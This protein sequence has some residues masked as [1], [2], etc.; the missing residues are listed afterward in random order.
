MGNAKSGQLK[1][2]YLRHKFDIL[3]AD[4]DKLIGAF[5]ILKFPEV[6]QDVFI[7][8]ILDPSIYDEYADIPEFTKKLSHS[9]PAICDFH[10][11][12]INAT[13]NE[14]YDLV[15]EYGSPFNFTLTKEEEIWQFIE[16]LLEGLTYLEAVGLH[17]P[18]LH[19]KYIVIV[20]SQGIKLVNPYCF[21]DFIK[22][23]LQIYLNPQNPVSNR[24]SYA[25][26]QISR[27]IREFAVLV[28][29][30]VSDCDDYQLRTDPQYLGKLL[31]MISKNFSASLV[32]LI[33]SILASPRPPTSFIAMN[34]LIR[35][36][37]HI[38]NSFKKP[39]PQNFNLQC[40]PNEFGNDFMGLNGIVGRSSNL[41]GQNSEKRSLEFRNRNAT[42]SATSN[43]RHFRD[44]AFLPKNLPQG[45][46]NQERKFK[47]FDDPAP[48]YTGRSRV[49]TPNK[50]SNVIFAQPHRVI[51]GNYPG[52]SPN[53]V[54]KSVHLQN[55]SEL[56]STK[57]QLAV[58]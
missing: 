28:C 32:S 26:N 37:N 56:I 41:T 21:P 42:F 13:N 2:N 54:N 57:F 20:D 31:E 15:Y 35:G 33:R 55:P 45:S 4:S 49:Q 6:S 30:V 46:A 53:V 7:L 12:E 9:C 51:P 5:K 10:F 18:I 23:V 58:Y 52:T 38:K 11:I 3:Q 50:N 17:Y 27:N 16:Q 29:S 14:L 48:E 1:E 44:L 25:Q 22:E 34:D 47:I 40:T 36:S 8:K 43:D 24:K 19:R 39:Q